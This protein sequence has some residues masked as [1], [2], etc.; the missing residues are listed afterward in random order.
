MLEIRGLT[1]HFGGLFAV[2]NLDMTI[3]QGEIAGLI[4]P[5]G[6]GKTTVFNL[7]TGFIA[8]T[9]GQII[10][11]QADITGKTTHSIAEKGVVRTFQQNAFLPD[12]TVLQN[13]L[14]SCYLHPKTGFWEAILNT[15]GYRKKEQYTCD[16]AMDILKFLGL[17]SFKEELAQNLPHGYQRLLGIAM[18]LSA[19]PKLI[20]LDEP[21]AG[22][23]AA[24]VSESLTFI[25]KMCSAGITVLLVEHN[26]R[27][28]MELCNRIV[29]INFG[30]KI[31]EG[32]PDEI[33]RNK[34]VIEAYLGAGE[35]VIRP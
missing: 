12:L 16:H 11:K 29:V 10:F 21:L 31:A 33:R 4:G 13:M 5:N 1:K 19:N 26:M 24:E 17:D 9:K 35:S 23:N 14:A 2:N 32:L 6:A 20:L 25:N 15:P 18:A 8:P 22:M 7:I 27:A 28:V 3:K 34:D 30:R